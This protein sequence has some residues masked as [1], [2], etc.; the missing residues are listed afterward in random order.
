MEEILHNQMSSNFLSWSIR[1]SMAEK[2]A[3]VLIITVRKYK[4][5]F[6]AIQETK[7]ESIGLQLINYYGEKA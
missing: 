6:F 4:P 2:K 7:C 5:L 1:G 3:R